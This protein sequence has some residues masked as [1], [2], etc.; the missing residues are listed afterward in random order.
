MTLI[1]SV[2]DYEIALWGFSTDTNVAEIA[3]FQKRWEI[4]ITGHFSETIARQFLLNELN[5]LNIKD[6][7]K[8]FTSIYILKCLNKL[9]VHNLRDKLTLSNELL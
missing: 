5:L 9:T 6:R 7:I 1:Q 2:T 4:L 3:R 8:Y